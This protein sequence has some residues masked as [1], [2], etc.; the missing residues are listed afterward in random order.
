MKI[1]DVVK[2]IE[3]EI[4]VLKK[5]VMNSNLK[6]EN[7]FESNIDF[8][9]DDDGF[10]THCLLNKD[11]DVDITFK[12]N[13][14]IKELG[15][16]ERIV[17]FTNININ[18]IEVVHKDAFE[19]L[20]IKDAEEL[21]TIGVDIAINANF[22]RLVDEDTYTTDDLDATYLEMTEQYRRENY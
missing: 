18:E 9:Y 10:Y 20:D 6:L 2:D 4:E 19:C 14:R 11:T 13:V 12:A 1:N 16:N 21:L 7:K 3:K 15:F 17:E 22:Y 8:Y 5:Q